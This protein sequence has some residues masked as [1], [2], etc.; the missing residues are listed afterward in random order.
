M[1]KPEVP[2]LLATLVSLLLG[3]LPAVGAQSVATVDLGWIELSQVGELWTIAHVVNPLPSADAMRG[4]D[5]VIS[6]DDLQLDGLNALSVARVLNRVLFDAHRVTV[7]RAAATIT[8]KLHSSSEPLLQT[9]MQEANTNRVELYRTEEH[10]PEMH[11]PDASGVAHT[12]GFREKWTVVHIWN[13]HCDPSEITA[14]NEIANPS[15]ENL[16]VVGIAMN[17]TAK[18]V[19]QFAER[20]EIEF[21]NVLGGAYDGDF[22]RKFNYFSLRT[23]ILVNPEGKVVFVG[24]GRNALGQAWRIFRDSQQ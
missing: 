7:L 8:L 4:G 13:T 6:I 14:L 1:R 11:L 3:C 19:T 12:I 2:K 16:N 24:S 9:L 15:P 5:T 22:A 17:D 23:D 21:L 10:M 20:Q 18:T